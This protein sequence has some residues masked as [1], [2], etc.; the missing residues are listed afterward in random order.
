MRGRQGGQSQ[1]RCDDGSKG[2][3]ERDEDA[4]TL[5]LE[6]KEGAMSQGKQVASRNWEKQGNRFSPFPQSPESTQLCTLFVGF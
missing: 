2:Q 3:K 4:M 1:R 5:P 6:M